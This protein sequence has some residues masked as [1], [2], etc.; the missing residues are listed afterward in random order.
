MTGN[1]LRRNNLLRNKNIKSK[2]S[3]R[4]KKGGSTLKIRNRV[5]NGE[6]SL[7]SKK[8]RK[9]LRIKKGG[10]DP[11]YN[12]Y[13]PPPPPEFQYTYATLHPNTKKKNLASPGHVGKSEVIAGLEKNKIA[14]Q[15]AWDKVYAK[16][17]NNIARNTRKVPINTRVLPTNKQL[18]KPSN[19]ISSAHGSLIVNK[20]VLKQFPKP[21]SFDEE[22]AIMKEFKKIEIKFITNIKETSDL[23]SIDKIMISF[24]IGF[25][26]LL[27]KN[28]RWKI[29][30]NYRQQITKITILIETIRKKKDYNIIKQLITDS[31]LTILS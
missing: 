4:I 14:E 1:S 15:A 8:R 17:A 11:V 2:R 3:N 24:E 18:Q 7:R 23:L 26:K 29:P 20:H 22:Q 28:P 30:P 16:Y 21:L 27:R 19:N 10:Q 9:I 13:S 5:R 6:K 31:N 25:T 12:P